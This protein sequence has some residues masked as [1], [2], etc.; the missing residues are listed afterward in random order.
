MYFEQLNYFCEV[1]RTRSINSASLNL[2]ISQQSLS[3][4]IRNLEKEYDTLFF[5]RSS[6]GVTPTSEGE[7]F[8]RLAKNILK[9]LTQFRANVHPISAPTKCTIGYLSSNIAASS[10]LYFSLRQQYPNV[11]FDISAFSYYNLLTIPSTR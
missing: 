9:D 4:S 5:I 1:Y 8:Y 2:N 6:K 10:D 7:E 11:R 3:S